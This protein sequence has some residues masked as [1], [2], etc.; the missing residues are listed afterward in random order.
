SFRIDGLPAAEYDLTVSASGKA[1]LGGQPPAGEVLRGSTKC[2]VPAVLPA[3]GPSPIDLGTIKLTSTLP[4]KN[5][6]PSQGAGT[7]PNS[8]DVLARK[9]SLLAKALPLKDALARVAR[10]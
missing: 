4:A 8:K 7:P 6:A 10:S 9:V 3:G 5:A 2:T 1:V